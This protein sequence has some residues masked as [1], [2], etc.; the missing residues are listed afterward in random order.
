MDI[1]TFSNNVRVKIG[2]DDNE[3]LALA[4]FP[5]EED[6]PY[7]VSLYRYCVPGRCDTYSFAWESARSPT[8]LAYFSDGWQPLG[9]SLSMVA[10]DLDKSQVVEMCV[11]AFQ[12]ERVVLHY[13]RE[14]LDLLQVIAPKSETYRRVQELCMNTMAERRARIQAAKS[15]PTS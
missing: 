5:I 12:A 11:R 6:R 15:S 2:P 14:F 8:K 9:E 7:R 10:K 1:P 3:F 13:H 4:L